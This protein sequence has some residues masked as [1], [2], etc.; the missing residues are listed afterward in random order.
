MLKSS[1]FRLRASK[2]RKHGTYDEWIKSLE[3]LNSEILGGDRECSA[4]TASVDDARHIETCDNHERHE[5]TQL[6]SLVDQLITTVSNQTATLSILSV[7]TS[8]K[9][10]VVRLGRFVNHSVRRFH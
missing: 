2:R 4:C 6:L 9:A 1:P 10:E 7:V 8:A 5:H 3:V